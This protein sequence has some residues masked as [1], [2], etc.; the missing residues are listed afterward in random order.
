QTLI[1]TC[2]LSDPCGTVSNGVLTFNAIAD[3]AMADATGI[4]A[5]A[6]GVNSDDNFVL[7][8]TA[9]ILDVDNVTKIPVDADL[10]FNTLSA[11]AGGVIQVLSGSITEGNM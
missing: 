9:G 5:W 8:M 6:R 10:I 2:V 4:L 11:Q 1:G 7:D 3:D